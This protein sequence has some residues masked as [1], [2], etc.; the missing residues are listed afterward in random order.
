VF[1]HNFFSF[2]GSLWTFAGN[3]MWD[4]PCKMKKLH[5]PFRDRWVGMCLGVKGNLEANLAPWF[6]TKL[7][8]LGESTFDY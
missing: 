1:F 5:F 6:E 4:M 2:I 8:T 7:K 3:T